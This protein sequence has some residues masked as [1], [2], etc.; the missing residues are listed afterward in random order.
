MFL[1]AT[2]VTSCLPTSLSQGAL[3]KKRSDRAKKKIDKLASKYNLK[4]SVSLDTTIVKYDTVVKDKI[5]YFTDTI[6]TQDIYFDSVINI[7]NLRIDSFMGDVHKMF[8]FRKDNL[9]GYVKLDDKRLQI[10]LHKQRDTIYFKDSIF[11]HDTIYH[12]EKERTI[13]NQDIVNTS[14]SFPWELWYFAKS[15]YLYIVVLIL[16][17]IITKNK[18]K[19]DENK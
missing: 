3:D 1:C 16:I 2:C 11:I 5:R 12:V 15:N 14:K 9:E 18:F 10:S 7:T 8:S 6:Y 17:V 13:N 4:H 19:R